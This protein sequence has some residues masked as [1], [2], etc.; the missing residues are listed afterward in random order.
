MSTPKSLIAAGIFDPK[1]LVNRFI[2]AGKM[3]RGETTIDYLKL[4]MR[5]QNRQA[6]RRQNL[7][8]KL[9]G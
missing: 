9:K 2:A 3:K 5:E 8:K 1:S 6:K 7:K 4:E